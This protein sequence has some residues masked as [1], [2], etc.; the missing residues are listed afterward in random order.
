MIGL[1]LIIS[2]YLIWYFNSSPSLDAD[3]IASIQQYRMPSPPEIITVY[4]EGTIKQF[5][6]YFNALDFTPV[7]LIR[8]PSGG[9]YARDV[10][11]LKDS[12]M[13]NNIVCEDAGD[14]QMLVKLNHRYYKVSASSYKELLDIISN[15]SADKTYGVQAGD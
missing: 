9:W 11:E 4:T 13:K 6:E 12:G 7:L 14:D 3:E 2:A 10:I 1:A 5:V 15:S 8:L